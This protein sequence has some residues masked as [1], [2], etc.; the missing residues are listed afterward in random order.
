MLRYRPGPIRQAA[1]LAAGFIVLRVAYRALFHGLDGSGAVLLDL[2]AVRLP[3]PFA[4]VVLFGPITVGGIGVAVASA[5]PIA[6]V[7]LAFG[8]LNAVV[9]LSRVFARAA[10]R[11]PVS[12]LSRALVI[13]WATF[14]GL[15]DAVRAV[16]LARRLRGERGAATLLVP[17]FERTVERALAVAAAMEV[18]GFTASRR[19]EGACA[20]PVV[21]HDAVLRRPDGWTLEVGDLELAPG[22]LALVAGP[23]GSGKSSLLDALSGMFS[24]AEG[25]SLSGV[26]RVGDVDRAAVPPRE[27]AGFVGVVRQDPRSGFASETVHAEIGF[28]LD[29]RGVAPVIVADRVR[30]VAGHVGVAHLLDRDIRALSAGEA[31]LVAIAAAIVERPSLVLVDEPLADLDRAARRRVA[32]L[33]G[34]LAHEAG[35]C[36][37]VA[38]HRVAELAPVADVALEIEGG[39]LRPLRSAEPGEAPG[40]TPSAA[41]APDADPA[42][43]DAPAAALRRALPSG[44]VEPVLRV[45][46][47]TVV[48]AGRTAVEDASLEVA[49]GEIVALAGPNGAGKSS[50]LVATALPTARGTVHV[51]G[52]DAARLDDRERRASVALVP[53]ASDDL[54][55]TLTAAEECRRADRGSGAEPGTTASRF[56]GFLGVDGAAADRLLARHPRDLS[57]GE[58]RCLAL[59]VQLA[60]DPSVL[61]V[62]EPTRGL[63]ADAR[64]LVSRALIAVAGRGGAV[65]VAT[66]DRAFA[67]ALADRIVPVRAGVVGGDPG[68]DLFERGDDRSLDAPGAQAA[69]MPEETAAGASDASIATAGGASATG[70][71]ADGASA[72]GA[73]AEPPTASDAGP[74]GVRGRSH[75]GRPGRDRPGI[76]RPLRDRLTGVVLALGTLAAVAAFAW[77]LLAPALP[78]QAQ[79]AAPVAA[80]ALA[81]FAL[82]VLVVALDESVRSARVLALLGTLAA[83]G[84]AVR[85]AGTGVGGVEAVFVLLIIGGRVFG[86]RFGFLLGVLVILLSSTMQGGFGPWTPFQA[87]AC[88]WV[89]AGAG[90]LPRGR[91]GRDARDP[92]TRA[93]RARR[94]R[95]REIA[96]LSAYGVVASYAFGLVMNLW[97]WPFAVGAGAGISYVPDAPL[98][99]N[100]GSFLLYSLVTSTASWDTLR[101]ITSVVGLVVAGPAALA[102]LRRAVVD[103]RPGAG[104]GARDGSRGSSRAVPPSATDRR[105]VAAPR[106]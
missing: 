37:V 12:G 21:A 4:H 32:D 49:P 103:D 55:V 25:G 48:H 78:S 99:Q 31:T 28:A 15:G 41:S 97:F 72:D 30:E 71:S 53:E 35:V 60:A 3:D 56:L 17:V 77:P 26:V 69:A 14:P 102:A 24:H 29:V 34:A 89:G 43:M 13:A 74:G 86:A 96:L 84:A 98:A 54:F 42:A 38:E 52:F 57:A 76:G 62:D 68:A 7:I 101:A 93:A 16:R 2:P 61:L 67:D 51:G 47:L 63:D 95:G 40:R 33:L 70:A 82:A 73:S 22:T 104:A 88:G 87:F 19:V 18:R 79:A 39:R 10:R 8:V 106:S 66:H 83:V 23:T 36:V 80:L 105:S 5:L 94:A 45:S 50:L 11:G 6:L 20:R 85:V 46:G 91:V 75:R 27:T 90:L 9:D 59:A 100:L 92:G 58:R 64:R 65:V 44:A 81:P 1:I